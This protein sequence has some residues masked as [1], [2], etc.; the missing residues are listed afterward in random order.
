MINKKKQNSEEIDKITK[1]CKTV[2]DYIQQL[3][4][5]DPNS[6]KIMSIFVTQIEAAARLGNINNMNK[7]RDEIA[8]WARNLKEDEI[9]ILNNILNE[10]FSEDLNSLK[11]VKIIEGVK[12]KGRIR[13]LKEYELVKRY[14]DDHF[15]NEKA[16]AEMD[17]IQKLI[18]QYQKETGN[19]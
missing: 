11:I 6:G 14:F 4:I 3:A 9:L 10:Q 16:H 15:M 13:N 5:S 8:E 1:W 19:F 2:L 17:A 7:I 18:D 12:K